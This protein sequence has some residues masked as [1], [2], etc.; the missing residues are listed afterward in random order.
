MN[1]QI[2]F[3]VHNTSRQLAAGMALNAP[4]G[5]VVEFKDPT[6]THMQNACMWPILEAFSR[7]KQWEVN[8]ELKWLTR[9][10]WKDLLSASYK[11]ES[12]QLAQGIDGGMVALG[13]RTSI[14]GKREFSEFIDYLKAVA[15]EMGIELDHED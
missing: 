2:F 15:A 14:M 7:Q 10:N 6:R 4:D 13:V 1:K 8:G 5:T 3:L 11:R 12:L 9:D